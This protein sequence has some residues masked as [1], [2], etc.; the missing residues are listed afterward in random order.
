[1]QIIIT[2][3]IPIFCL[4]SLG[5]ILRRKF[6]KT[7]KFWAILDS[8]T[9]YIF[10]PSLLFYKIAT[11]DIQSSNDLVTALILVLAA[12]FIISFLAIIINFF[13]KFEP[14][15][16]TSVFQGA[17]RY[18]TYIFLGI[19]A[20]LYGESGLVTAAFLMAFIIP[21]I[22]ILCV[23]VFAIY[24]KNGKFSPINTVKNI[25]K[26][27]LILA[28]V[29]GIS[30][31][32]IGIKSDILEP[33]GLIGTAAIAT[34]LLSVGAGL[35]FGEIV[36]LKTSFY[37]SS[38]LKL[39]LYPIIV[40]IGSK[41]LNLSSQAAMICIIFASMPTATSSYILA[42]QMGG[43][44]SLMSIIITLQTMISVVSIWLVYIFA[45]V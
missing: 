42:S 29:F 38:F 4:I 10:I 9:Y 34:G 15:E 36:N 40:F 39:I 8:M 19:V 6:Y 22:N 24:I 1:M 27:P 13:A 16:F 45:G 7:A 44:K 32:F 20:A 17:I 30:T 33:I 41:M 11:A 31:N 23:C 35:K 43:D 14:A 37:V 28:C 25:G 12:L 3:I 21:V 2:A 26:N 18:N 5:F